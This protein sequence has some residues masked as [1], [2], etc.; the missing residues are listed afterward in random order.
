MPHSST[1]NEPWSI[2]AGP[3]GVLRI[4]QKR[5]PVREIRRY[6]M[7]AGQERD[8]L[9]SLLN[10]SIYMVVAAAFLMLVVHFGWRER[11]LLG[12]IFFALV[13]STSIIDILT[14]SPVRLYRV[15]I[16]TITGETI[17]FTSADAR[18]IDKLAHTLDRLVG[19]R[20]TA[21]LA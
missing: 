1:V 21:R 6:T 2:A 13:A 8:Y 18:Q 10:C 14:A 7:Q 17:C 9:A 12:T 15:R 5:V 20:P 16:E 4:G 11:F 3:D 19:P